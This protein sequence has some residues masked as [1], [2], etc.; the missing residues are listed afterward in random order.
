MTP[1]P[2]S[3]FSPERVILGGRAKAAE[4]PAGANAASGRL[5]SSG[6]WGRWREALL[7]VGGVGAALLISFLRDSGVG[8]SGAF[9]IASGFF[10]AGGGACWASGSAEGV[11]FSWGWVGSGA[12]LCGG[13]ARLP[14]L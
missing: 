9:S 4:R 12:G 2:N 5:S 1:R 11:S 14:V 10:G 6:S 7:V 13:G 3:S 8:C